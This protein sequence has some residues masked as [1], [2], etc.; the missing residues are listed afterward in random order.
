MNFALRWLLLLHPVIQYLLVGIRPV[1]TLAFSGITMVVIVFL[2]FLNSN[3]SRT[4]IEFQWLWLWCI[5]Q[6][7]FL[8][9]KAQIDGHH[10][11][12]SAMFAIHISVFFLLYISTAQAKISRKYITKPLGY[13]CIAIC[14][15]SMFQKVGIHQFKYDAFACPGI[16]GNMTN[17]MMYAVALSPFLLQYKRGWI[18]L[19]IPLIACIVNNSASALL[20]MVSII[21]FF[22][23]Y[24]KMYGLLGT[25][26]VL[27]GGLIAIF[28]KHLLFFFNPYGKLEVWNE[29]VK[30]W[31]TSAWFGKGLGHFWGVYQTGNGTVNWAFMHNHYLYVLYALGIIGLFLLILFL[32]QS[33][34]YG[35][36]ILHLASVIAVLVMG[37]VS[38][39]MR[40]YPIV[41]LTAINLGVLRNYGDSIF[42]QSG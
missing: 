4:K 8:N 29:A 13:M 7:I 15:L 12:Y 18:Y 20:G 2:L 35:H 38:V 22:L 10:L 17:T 25:L 23:I 6:A 11:H 26:I 21:T 34:R 33:I 36:R 37:I 39:P 3:K 24:K 14:L 16:L 5:A 42:I 40:V 1:T 30:G 31:T 19:S 28:Y 9:W 41:L 27:F 32:K